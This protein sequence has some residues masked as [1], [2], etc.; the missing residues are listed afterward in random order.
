MV[1]PVTGIEVNKLTQGS[2]H[3]LSSFSS[4]SSP[5]SQRQQHRP[6]QIQC[7]RP[8]GGRNLPKIEHSRQPLG[9]TGGRH[10]T[11]HHQIFILLSQLPIEGLGI[12]E[13]GRRQ[14]GEAAIGH[15]IFVE[16]IPVLLGI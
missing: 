7:N 2:L 11:G 16:Q 5:A 14:G 1:V 6:Y 10:K 9:V 13:V 15:H 12:G 8:Q 4:P 3:S